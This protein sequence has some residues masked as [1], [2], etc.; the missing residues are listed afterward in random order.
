MEEFPYRERAGG[1]CLRSGDVDCWSGDGGG[2]S[3]GSG[4]S[5]I[6]QRRFH[7]PADAGPFADALSAVGLSYPDL[8]GAADLAGVL[9]EAGS[10]PSRMPNVGHAL[11]EVL[12]PA[13]RLSTRR[14]Q[15]P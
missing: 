8:V 11:A 12:H 9:T 4:R 6:E 15:S 2:G 5:W 10:R 3:G 14:L 7:Q 13:A 1:W